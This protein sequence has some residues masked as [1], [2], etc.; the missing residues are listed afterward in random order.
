MCARCQ[1]VAVTGL[2]AGGG[3]QGRSELGRR[4]APPGGEGARGGGG[5]K[6]GSGG[7]PPKGLP[8]HRA[9][10]GLFLSGCG[11][12]RSRELPAEGVFVGLGP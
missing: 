6:P 10:G 9:A 3:P 11:R 5:G 2:G 1:P 12:L 8:R 7:A 4:P